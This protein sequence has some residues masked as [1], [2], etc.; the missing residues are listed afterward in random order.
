MQKY[1][2][3]D[4]KT[5]IIVVQM[6]SFTKAAAQL[7][8]SPSAVSHL[9]KNLE[10]SLKIK[11][12]H[13]TTRAISP[14][15]AGEQ[16]YQ[17]L[18]PLFD[19]IEIKINALSHFRDTLAGSLRINGS[20]FAFL[21]LQQQFADFCRHYPEISLELISHQGFVDIVAER[22][23]AGIRLG[24][25]VEK[26]MVAVRITP[27]LKMCV[28]ATPEYLAQ[29]GT[30]KTPQDLT[31]HQCLT[32]RLPTS[33]GLMAWEFAK[34]G[35]RFNVKVAGR[36]VASASNIA[37]RYALQNLGLTW[38]FESTV[39]QEIAD[40]SLVKVLE[41]WAVEFDG[42]YLYYP[43]RKENLPALKAL[44]GWLRV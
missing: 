14:T 1:N 34:G 23:D 33:G 2:L 18:S 16:L 32:L 43:S 11:L 12:I 26:D 8:V 42:A 27:K 35:Q 17:E 28:V 3:N 20:D 38:V 7:G 25:Q 44:I 15:Q 6:G 5:F 40:G 10:Q 19:E 41:Q 37:V 22:F 4:L 29:H 31:E 13:R 36:L 9:I 39:A 24:N 30:P 21:Y